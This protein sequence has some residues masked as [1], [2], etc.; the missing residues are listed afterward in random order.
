MVLF[1]HL[2]PDTWI[3]S[4]A[5]SARGIS[6]A[7]PGKIGIS[8]RESFKTLISSDLFLERISRNIDPWGLGAWLWTQSAV[9]TIWSD[10]DDQGHLNDLL[11]IFGLIL[12]FYSKKKSS[13]LLFW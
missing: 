11:A 10:L 5:G 6:G 2:A 9:Y 8:W 3:N 12:V 4:L 1:P 13:K 7:G